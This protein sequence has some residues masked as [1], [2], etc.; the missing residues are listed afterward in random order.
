MDGTIKQM[1]FV[2]DKHYADLAVYLHDIRHKLNT[3]FFE[4]LNK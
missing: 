4:L 1:S 3:T 2:S